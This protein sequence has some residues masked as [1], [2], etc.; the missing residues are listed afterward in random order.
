M[1]TENLTEEQPKPKGKQSFWEL[2]RFAVLAVLIV[3]PVRM[4]IAQPFI[5]S[6]SSMAPT[7]GSGDYLVV[8]EIT[9]RIKDPQRYDVVI[10]KYPNDPEKFFIK[11]IIGLP[12][13][14]VEIRGNE[15]TIQNSEI[16]DGFPIEQ[17]YVKWQG[18]NNLRFELKE[19]EF[20]VMG[21]N[22][23]ASSDSRYWGAVPRE[24]L[25]GR[26]LLRL[27]PVHEIGI[28]PGG[29]KEER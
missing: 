5:V 2:V 1:E 20:F 8:D 15:V 18:N 3:V 27:L 13:E 22:R 14:T 16:P 28:L 6:G 7:F 19:D 23:S 10:F 17:P 4:F 9:Y 12:N 11:R 24:L 21:D 29:Y 25:S 26:A